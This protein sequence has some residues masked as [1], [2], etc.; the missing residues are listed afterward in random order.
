MPRSIGLFSSVAAIGVGLFV[1]ICG[2]W[3]NLTVASLSV[4]DLG[5]CSSLGIPE[6]V[7]TA[8][9]SNGLNIALLFCW[10]FGKSIQLR[11]AEIFFIRRL[12]VQ[13]MKQPWF[14]RP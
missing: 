12:Q 11:S 3:T 10:M 6:V 2:F 8:V 1:D 4:P 7:A 9:F 5:W 14:K 13:I